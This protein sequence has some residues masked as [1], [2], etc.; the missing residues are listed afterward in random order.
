[1][2]LETDFD[3]PDRIV[4]GYPVT[5]DAS[6]DGMWCPANADPSMAGHRTM[7][8]AFG[9][10]VNTYFVWLAERVGA[11][12]VVEMAERL[13]IVLRAPDDA[14]LARYGARQWGPFTLGVAATTPLD[15]ANAYAT[16]AAEGIW[17]APSP[18]TSITDSAGRK[19]AAGQPD[20]RQVVDQD[21][22]RAAADA[23]RCPVGD[24][25]M[26]NRCDGGTAPE[27]RQRLGR[28]VAGKTG[29]SEG[30]GTES[31][32]A[33]TPQLAVA[34]IAANPDDPRDAV[35]KEVQARMVE[36]VGAV[37]AGTLR[38]QPVRDFVPPS[39]SVTYRTTSPRS[40]N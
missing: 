4:T 16:V 34:S 24:Q 17:C 27:L 2:P 31:V 6:C 38:D 19:V 32:V 18:V 37:L 40:G 7:W 26:Y 35:G 29:S 14:R 15:L 11:D 25:S 28:P 33:F 10:S 30:Y 12:R 8:T 23:A 20:C 22:A 9:R 1:M 13:G 3:A 39:E 21:V 36:A 5:G